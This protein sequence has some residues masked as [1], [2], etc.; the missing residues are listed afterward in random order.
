MS[1]WWILITEIISS[2]QSTDLVAPI[3]SVAPKRNI[4]TCNSRKSMLMWLDIVIN[5][6]SEPSMQQTDIIPAIR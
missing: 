3:N 4:R 5:N 1:R 2:S 6:K